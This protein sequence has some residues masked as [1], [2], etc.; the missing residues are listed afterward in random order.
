LVHSRVEVQV[1]MVN[2]PPIG[3]PTDTGL[4][5][6]TVTLVWS[7]TALVMLAGLALLLWALRARDRTSYR[8][9]C[10]EHGTEASIRVRMRRRDGRLDVD[11]CSLCSPPT[12]VECRKGCLRLVA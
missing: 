11:R 12:R 4:A 8:L 3:L 7:I 6:D 10:P 5:F 9:R 1:A 2:V